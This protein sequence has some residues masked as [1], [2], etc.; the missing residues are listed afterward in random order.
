MKRIQVISGG[1][2]GV[3]RAALDAALEAGFDIGGW[4]PPGK[5]A[6]DGVI[7]V[8]YPLKATPKEHSTDA[9][10]VPRSLRT[11]WNVRDADVTVIILPS[12]VA[13][14]AGT[15]YTIVCAKQMKKPFEITDPMDEQAV[16]KIIH[17]LQ[18]PLSKGMKKELIMNIAGPSDVLFPGIYQQT[19]GLLRTVFQI[20]IKQSTLSE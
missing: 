3:D 14:D 7:P 11:R 8:R 9:P 18:Q 20:L 2:T 15:D 12:G 6:H 13:P 17:W 4:G 19:L 10:D 1:Q 16:G 5:V